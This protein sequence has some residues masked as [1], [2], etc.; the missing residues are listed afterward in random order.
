MWPLHLSDLLLMMHVHVFMVAWISSRGVAV[1][2]GGGE[3]ADNFGKG[4]V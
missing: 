2:G 3:G 1:G 4:G